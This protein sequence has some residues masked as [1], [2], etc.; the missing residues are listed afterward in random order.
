MLKNYFKTTFRVLWRKKGYSL[1]NIL[2]LSLG[3]AGCILIL[4][5]VNYQ[6]NFDAFHKDADQIYRV[7]LNKSQEGRLF[8]RVRLILRRLDQLWKRI[9][10]K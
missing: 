5:Y 3:I 10:L 1:I 9:F 2:G 7:Q 4:T 8:L 6:L